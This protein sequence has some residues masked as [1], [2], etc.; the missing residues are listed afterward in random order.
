MDDELRAPLLALHKAV[1]AVERRN[2]E[3]VHGPMSAAEFLQL[4]SDPLR[5]GW[6]KPLT[7]LVLAAEGSAIAVFLGTR[8]TTYEHPPPDGR[9]RFLAI[10]AMA[11]N[12][13]FLMV[14]LLSGVAASLLAV[15]YGA[16]SAGARD[17]SRERTYP[18]VVPRRGR[19]ATS[20]ST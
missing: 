6:L 4:V 14:I 7:E 20:F 13:V 2:V 19:A 15:G 16:A 12:V 10:A 11:A 9:I 3:R 5:Y 1:L 8:R 18:R 17:Q